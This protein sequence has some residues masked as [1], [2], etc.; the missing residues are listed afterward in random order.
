MLSSL[1]SPDISSDLH[2]SADNASIS[3]SLATHDLLTLAQRWIEGH[4]P[5]W[6]RLYAGQSRR[7]LALPT[8]PFVR[9]T[10]WVDA[11]PVLETVASAE[12]LHPLLHRNTSNAFGLRFTSSFSGREFFLADHVVQG[13]PTLPAAAQLEMVRCSI[14]QALAAQGRYR[15]KDVM[16]LRPVVVGEPS[17]DLHVALFP[18]D[19]GAFGFELFSG[20][21]GDEG[22]VYGEGSIVAAPAFAQPLQHDLEALRRDCTRA[23]LVGEACYPAFQ[24]L[25]LDYGPAHRGLDALHIGNE[26]ALARIVVPDV[27]KAQRESYVLHPS[28]LDAALQAAIAFQA[29]GN[30]GLD[31][32][33][34]A[35]PF[36]LGSLDIQG[37]CNADMWAVLRPS[38]GHTATDA[39]QKYD[40]DFCDESGT[41]QARLSGLSLRASSQVRQDEPVQ[42]ALLHPEWIA[43]VIDDSAP[44]YAGY[45]T[46][47]CGWDAET[48]AAVRTRLS[49][50]HYFAFTTEHDFAR[51]YAAAA[52]CLLQQLQRLGREAGPQLVQIVVPN[53]GLHSS[54]AGLAG[55]LRT[56]QLEYPHIAGQVIGAQA[57]QDL[58]QLV[59]GNRRSAAIRI[60]Y[61]DGERQSAQWSELTNVAPNPITWRERGVYLITGGAGGLGLIFARDIAREAKGATLVLTGRSKPNQ[62]MLA[63]FAELEALGASVRYR[64]LDVGDRQ[65]VHETVRNLVAEFGALHSVL[66]SAGIVR[67]SFIL[68]KTPEELAAVLHAKVAGTLHL[69]EAT[70]DLALDSFI[71]FASI[72]GALGNIGQA[73]YAAANAFMDAFAHHRHALQ[74]QGLRQGQSLAVDWPLWSE[75]GMQVDESLRQGLT[76]QLGLIPLD[77]EHGCA[78]LLQALA[79]GQPQVLVVEGMLRRF[80]A[81]LAPGAKTASVVA[82]PVVETIVAGPDALQD[83]AE[84][85]FVRLLSTTL[86]RPAHSID[87]RA[88]MEAYGIDSILV[89]ELTR[90]LEQVF[91]SLSKTLLFEYQTLA[92]LT[93]YFLQHHRARLIELLGDVSRESV[94]V[95]PREEG[96]PAATT[97]STIRR[98]RFG[99][100]ENN[101]HKTASASATLAANAIGDIAIVGVAG[102]YPQAIDLDQFWANLS[103]GRDSITEIPLER[104]DHAQYFDA[105]R[106][107][108]GKTYS[109]W[110]GFIDGVDQFD[111]LFF[112]IS[113]REAELMDPQ[114]RLFLECVHATLEDAGYTRENVAE[115]N[116][117]GVFVGVMYEEYQLF[118]AQEQARGRNLALL[119]SAASVANRVS[120]F[121]NFNGPSL[122]LDTMC[123]SS[124][125]AIH[126]A[127]QALQRGGC[128][129]AIAG[130]VNVSV[131]PNKYLMLAQ[132][133]F[134]S[135]KGRC[136]SFGEGGEGYVPGEG[137][138]AVLLKPLA[139]AQADGDHIYGV[140]R[141]TAINHGGKTNGYT[142]PNPN[143]QAKVIERA[144]R[145]ARIDARTVSYIE[146]HGTGTSLGDPIEISGLSKAF[147]QWTTDRQLLC[148][149]F[150]QIQYRSLRKCRRYCRH[151]QGVVAA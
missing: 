74:G 63:K 129:V 80:M 126:L 149:R 21:D 90:A 128:T 58:A 103:Q 141:A 146:A 133:K 106:S 16:W 35:L 115:D 95:Q 151:N 34:L 6:T 43:Q 48:T 26:L 119:N 99:Q 100:H 55:M 23:H 148:N 44:S 144:L 76:Q 69:D 86:K 38:A 67:D 73:D 113:P 102:R 14:E 30:G 11:Q 125:T 9:E 46:L 25:G 28:V 18:G 114:E 39:L 135:G 52:E 123:S 49:E 62:V 68:K 98:P 81:G 109:K 27:V 124:L 47:L 59:L 15:I 36:A 138:G 51:A 24:R 82:P 50:Q 66:H 116:N 19:N 122:A 65:A 127:C 3:S 53:D 8:Y 37:P 22:V 107:K 117:V 108:A 147:G 40:I 5:D 97:A 130:G 1:L 13:V 88:Q 41:V 77:S 45:L 118:A 89:M 54:F 60:R 92:A 42:V 145:E 78:A 91:G 137:V 33:N 20:N 96:A 131:H 140:I 84:R 112:N 79:T 70:A 85:Y 32:V 12:A 101:F 87:P 4:E 83:K 57:G 104:W 29:E 110:G 64:V 94:A 143:A 93:A 72:S 61:S 75:G 132:G 71:C 139:Q 121:C 56:A 17:L 31:A 10:H 2:E 142:V 150:G 105:D 134:I 136:E 7:R 120:Y 111:P